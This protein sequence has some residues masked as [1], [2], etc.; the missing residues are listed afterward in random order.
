MRVLYVFFVYSTWHLTGIGVFGNTFLVVP[1]TQ[2]HFLG[3]SFGFSLLVF[4]KILY[5]A[6]T[7]SNMFAQI[8]SDNISDVSEWFL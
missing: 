1:P 5:F 2:P 8:F 7:L 3:Q 6:T 4:F